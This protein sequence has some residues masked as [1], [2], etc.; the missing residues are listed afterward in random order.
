MKSAIDHKIMSVY[1]RGIVD[2]VIV[3]RCN[4]PSFHDLDI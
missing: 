1:N 3:T 2:N 4:F